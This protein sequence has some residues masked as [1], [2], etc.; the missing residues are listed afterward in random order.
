MGEDEKVRPVKIFISYAHE[1]EDYKD[2]LVKHLS[3]LRNNGYIS[4]WTDREILPGQLWDRQIKKNLEEADIVLF[5]VSSDFM[6]SGYIH[7][8]EIAKAM[9]R[10]ERGEGVRIIPFVLRPCDL[11]SLKLSVF[12]ALPKNAKPVSK[13]ENQDEA[14]LDAVNQL[15]RLI[16]EKPAAQANSIATTPEATEMELPLD[17]ER[18][19][20]RDENR[21]A[22]KDSFASSPNDRQDESL[23]PSERD[24]THDASER[25]I[26][27][28]LS[29]GGFRATIFHL[30]VLRF[31]RDADALKHVKVV[32][33]VSGGSIVAAHLVLNWAEYC[34]TATDFQQAE[35]QLKNFIQSDVRNRIF[36]RMPWVVILRRIP[37]LK[38]LF[39]GV[40]ASASELL[41]HE[42]R[43]LFEGKML[44]DFPNSAAN[45]EQSNIKNPAPQI[46]IMTTSVNQP[47]E[48]CWFSGDGLHF[49]STK[50]N[51]P[52]ETAPCV[53]APVALAVASSSVFPGAFPPLFVDHKTLHVK[54]KQLRSSHYL[55]DGGVFDN[56]GAKKARKEF[57]RIGSENKLLLVSNASRGIDWVPASPL[58]LR[59]TRTLLRCSEIL[60]ARVAEEV[61]ADL[62]SDEIWAN[63]TT[64]PMATSLP[65]DVLYGI[66]QTRTDLDCFTEK[67]YRSL[68]DLGYSIAKQEF[69]EKVGQS[70]EGSYQP[71]Q[72]FP[73]LKLK[74]VEPWRKG[75]VFRPLLFGWRDR[76][77]YYNGL[78]ALLCAAGL[79][80]LFSDELKGLVGGDKLGDGGTAPTPDVVATE[81]ISIDLE[82]FL[83]QLRITESSRREELLAEHLGKRVVNWRLYVHEYQPGNI[84]PCYI[85]KQSSEAENKLPLK[86]VKFLVVLSATPDVILEQGAVVYVSGIIER[87]NDHEVV[88]ERA[89]VK[90]VRP[91]AGNTFGL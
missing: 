43:R 35:K 31:L 71:F 64:Q 45:F 68:F 7:D 24:N 42:Y 13:W 78:L 14:F 77:T 44:N 59:T 20:V 9:G 67:E 62:S 11:Q 55:T 26:H 56:S 82:A 53:S 29:G 15:K 60:Q 61:E 76:F 81:D 28:A 38:F 75:S 23:T 4:E 39:R 19:T 48:A 21:A 86:Y 27:L 25:I 3:G 47:M 6:A 5:L 91:A 54:A 50:T 63:I 69:S 49:E 2:K 12:H 8:K 18:Q 74:E 89:V 87:I 90:P 17:V 16:Q 80:W 73:D 79:I 10:H 84:S 22:D 66:S 70:R 32:T 37:L 33:S 36:R 51:D 34:G 83:E 1:D 52:P 46:R 65:K 41:I 40:S 58:D 30:G 72:S 57:S 85:C 88:I